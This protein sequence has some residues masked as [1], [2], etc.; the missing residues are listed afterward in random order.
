MRHIRHRQAHAN[1]AGKAG[2]SSA[3]NR[4]VPLRQLAEQCAELGIRQSRDRQIKGRSGVYWAFKKK[5]INAV[6]GEKLAHP[7]YRRI[8]AHQRSGGG[9]HADKQG[10][11][12]QRAK[13][14]G[15]GG[16]VQ[17]ILP[18]R[19]HR[20][21]KLDDPQARLPS[22]KRR[23]VQGGRRGWLSQGIEAGIA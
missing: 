19:L 5:W 22:G 17:V 7:P 2:G 11:I 3:V 18:C 14:L 23:R 4:A 9:I 6:D 1:V 21:M 13:D 10:V 12:G 16:G 8:L 20:L 15:G